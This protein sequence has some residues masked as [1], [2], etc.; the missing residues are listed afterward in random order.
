MNRTKNI[1]IID[2]VFESSIVDSLYDSVVIHFKNNLFIEDSIDV[3]K[4]IIDC[5]GMSLT[6]CNY[7]PYPEKC[8]NVLCL[9]IKEHVVNYCKEFGYHHDDIIPFSC[10]SERVDPGPNSILK[11]D[12]ELR[13]IIPDFDKLTREDFR[14]CESE[15]YARDDQV[16]KHMIRTVYNLKNPESFFGTIIYF[17]SPQKIDAK[18][19]RLLIYDGF[20][21]LSHHFYPIKEID[22]RPKYNIIF[23][24]YINDPFEV[25]DWIIP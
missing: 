3:T 14:A 17:D 24:W 5:H 22:P 8:W 6:D 13:D 7:F 25:P 20:S 21:N 19:N 9:K 10:W 15:E 23:D 16:K 11:T 1:L 18:N 4:S 2:D 12:N